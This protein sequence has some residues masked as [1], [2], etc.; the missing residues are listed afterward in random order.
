MSK[1]EVILCE[2]LESSLKRAIDNCPHDRLFILTDDHT[3]RLCLSQLA[4]LSILKDA[5]EITIGAEDVHK[6]SKPWP[7]SGRYYEKGATRHSLLINLGA[8]WSLI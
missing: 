7:L 5:V 3:H 2:D 4:G 6:H 1:Q 8:E